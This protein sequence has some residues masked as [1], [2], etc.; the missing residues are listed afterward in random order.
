MNE[1]DDATGETKLIWCT[2]RVVC[3]L[4]NDNKVRIEWDDECEE[5]SDEKGHSLF[6][7]SELSNTRLFR[8]LSLY[9]FA[10]AAAAATWSFNSNFSR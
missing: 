3:L 4:N 6:G 5:D 1:V 7:R 9:R 2:G 8:F 10:A